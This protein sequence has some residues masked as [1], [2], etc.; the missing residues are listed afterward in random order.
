[1]KDV[2]IRFDRKSPLQ[3][4]LQ[5]RVDA[6]FAE[7]GL[8]PKGGS[9]LIGKAIVIGLWLTA[10]YAF[11]MSGIGG[12]AGLLLGAMMV[13]MAQAG[14][15]FNIMH[16]GNHGAF[17]T[18]KRTNLWMGR[19]LDLV[20]GS[21]YIWRQKHNVMHHTYPN[22][23][24]SDDDI[25]VGG[26]A[27]L[28]PAQPYHPGYR[29]QHFYMWIL[30]GFISVKWNFYD[31]FAQLIRGH[32]G[33]HRFPRPKRGELV[34]FF[35]AKALFFGWVI[36]APIALF[37][38]AKGVAFYFVEAFTLGVTL[39]VVFQ[40][41]HCVEEADFTDVPD[42]QVTELDFAEHQLNTTVDF[43]RGNPFVTWYL[44][45]LNYQAIHHLF[46]KISHVHYPA[47]SPIVE[48]VCAEF[49]VPYRINGG[50][51]E[52]VGSHYRWLKRMG[53]APAVAAQP[54]TA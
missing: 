36:I 53:Q 7:N 47:I 9:P 41:A 50:F 40:L 33:G 35:V 6:Y 4:A 3:A 15:G 22:V 13:G 2:R 46:P 51:W 45:G 52:S 38:L 24:G 16:D 12:W 44:G 18:D 43:A 37:G 42:G 32:L 28:A 27:R 54:V 49:N 5:T 25:D 31:D 29:L 17:S 30:Y 1:M 39:A 11:A 48:E 10:A 20:G 8:N 26:L 23:V 14:V 21:S 19:V 34:Y